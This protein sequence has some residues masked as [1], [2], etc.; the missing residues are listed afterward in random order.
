MRLI[1]SAQS[2]N[3][4]CSVYEVCFLYLCLHPFPLCSPRSHNN[5]ES[6]MMIWVK[7]E[8]KKTFWKKK[9]DGNWKRLNR[10]I[11]I[12][13][14]G[15]IFISRCF[16]SGMPRKISKLQPDLFNERLSLML[17][18]W[19]HIPLTLEAKA[20]SGRGDEFFIVSS[21]WSHSYINSY[22]HIRT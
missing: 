4:A 7:W 2:F 11:N 14:W 17:L 16:S 12:A 9:L 1:G 5:I 3:Y 13:L 8:K 10:T 22:T 19:K 21:N 18:G 15:R 20:P 6:S